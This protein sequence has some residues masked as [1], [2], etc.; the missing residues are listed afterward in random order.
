MDQLLGSSIALVRKLWM[1]A[2]KIYFFVLTED[3]L[4]KIFNPLIFQ[5][6]GLFSNYDTKNSTYA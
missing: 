6:N 3:I 4:L 2:Y 5:M 1:N